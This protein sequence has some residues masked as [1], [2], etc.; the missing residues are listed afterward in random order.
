MS[1]TY[2]VAQAKQRIARASKL[3]ETENIILHDEYLRETRPEMMGEYV[4]S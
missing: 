1:G 3:A 2:K 4:N